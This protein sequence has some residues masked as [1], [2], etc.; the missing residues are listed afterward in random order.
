M[1]PVSSSQS[2][3]IATPS[4]T[5]LISDSMPHPSMTSSTIPHLYPPPN[6]PPPPQPHHQQQASPYPYP[7]PPTYPQQHH[8]YSYVTPSLAH[9]QPMHPASFTLPPSATLFSDLPSA[10][11]SAA[12]NSTGPPAFY[13]SYGVYQPIHTPYP[14]FLTPSPEPSILGELDLD[15]LGTAGVADYES[16]IGGG[17]GLNGIAEEGGGVGGDEEMNSVWQE[18]SPINVVETHHPSSL[19]NSVTSQHSVGEE[20]KRD[21][22]EGM[23]LAQ[24]RSRANSLEAVDRDERRYES[25]GAHSGLNASDRAAFEVRDQVNG[26]VKGKSKRK[27]ST[28]SN[29]GGGGGGKKSNFSNGTS[30]YTHDSQPLHLDSTS[31]TLSSTADESSPPTTI[32]GVQKSANSLLGKKNRNPHATQLPGNG[33]RKLPKEEA[34]EGHQ[35]PIC[36]HC[37]SIT[38]PLWRRGPDDE[39]L[40]NA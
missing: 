25:F 26:G 32:D 18:F 19:P 24:I 38:T 7:H 31:P 15:G 6:V 17:N 16:V 35:G 22:F 10:L 29:G 27:N 11:S 12:P 33:Q 9:P 8:P 3:I 37:A 23:S 14:R 5:A 39:L 20:N 4:W 2:R 28:E 30:P 1:P 21:P 36:S 34:G 13:S 40:C